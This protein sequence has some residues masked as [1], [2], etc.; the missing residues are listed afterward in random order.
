MRARFRG[1]LSRRQA[2][3]VTNVVSALAISHLSVQ[4]CGFL[5]AGLPQ[6]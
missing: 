2:I 1:E 5:H 4:N 6:P 3:W